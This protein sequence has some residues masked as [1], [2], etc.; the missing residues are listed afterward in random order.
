MRSLLLLSCFYRV[1][2]PYSMCGCVH[3]LGMLVSQAGMAWCAG[4]GKSHMGGLVVAQLLLQGRVVVLELVPANSPA[5]LRKPL[6]Y[7]LQLTI[8]ESSSWLFR[9]PSWQAKCAATSSLPAYGILT[10]SSPVQMGWPACMR[11]RVTSTPV[12]GWSM[13]TGQ[14]T[15]T[16]TGRQPMWW[17][18][19]F[20]VSARHPSQSPVVTVQAVPVAVRCPSLQGGISMGESPEPKNRGK[21]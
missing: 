3:T 15:T 10:A 5:R 12:S 6:F 13:S 19:V 2:A 21:I 4:I 1:V 16:R 9:L 17:M 20:Q 11:S 8:G 14:W 7:R 18:G